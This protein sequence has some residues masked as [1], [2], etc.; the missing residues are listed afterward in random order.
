[1][2]NIIT[3]IAIAFTFSINSNAQSV[4]IMVSEDAFIQGGGTSNTAMGVKAKKA[5]KIKKS[6]ANS[7]YTRISYLKFETPKKLKKA[8]KITLHV[9]LLVYVNKNHPDRTFG[10]NIFAVE[11]DNWTEDTINWS[12]ALELG[13]LVGSM[14]VPQCLNN[15]TKELAIELSAEKVSLLFKGRNDKNITLALVNSKNNGLGATAPSKERSV[16]LASYLMIE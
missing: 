1:M 4:K 15:Q 9:P 8:D 13:E 6:K 14:E 2:K 12:E 11:N 5:L 10:L 16:N 7:A 3:I